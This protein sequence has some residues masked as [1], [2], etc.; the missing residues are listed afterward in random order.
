[1]SAFI[2]PSTNIGKLDERFTKLARRAKRIGIV[3]PSYTIVKEEPKSMQVN[4]VEKIIL[5]HYI[6]VFNPLVKI[7][8]YQ[9]V[10]TIEHTSEGNIIHNAKGET[11]PNEYRT[12]GP[13]CDHCRTNRRR[14][15]TFIVKSD[16]INVYKQIGR[17]C[18]AEFFGINAENYAAM[19][20]MCYEVDEL[21]AASESDS[22][23]EGGGGGKSYDYLDRFLSFVAECISQ[24]GWVSR[25]VAK[26]HDGMTATADLAM[27]HMYPFRREG[28]L[29][30]KPSEKS[31][32]TA[33]LAIEWCEAISDE[34][35]EKSEYLHNIRVIARRGVVER[36]QYGY[37]ASIV[38]SYLRH[39]N[40][41]IAKE[42]AALNPSQHVGEVGK[43]QD[44][45]L[46]VDKVIQIDSQYGTSFMHLMSDQDNNKF[47]WKASGTCLDTGTTVTLKGT[48][49]SHGEFRGMNQTTLTRCKVQE[50]K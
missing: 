14:N 11:V 5:M 44:F 6:E 7:S 48:I 9:F 35:T 3:V 10:A 15:D 38:S 28:L 40:D 16:T 45:T 46:L 49:K 42:R 26:D 20:E 17:N 22:F 39:V 23:D 19:A 21:C 13:W 47:V 29:F 30:D 25:T 50:K 37:A 34:E 8:G 12:C 4:G 24:A 33:K 41:L 31:I 18:L 43:R 36:R 1:M 27:R 32:E 2:I